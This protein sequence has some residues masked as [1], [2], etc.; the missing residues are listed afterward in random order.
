MYWTGLTED[1][2]SLLQGIILAVALVFLPVV[3]WLARR[4]EKKTAYIIAGASWTLVM[5]AIWPVPPQARAPI[6]VL[7]ALAGFGVAAAHLIPSAMD[8]DVLE[9]DE[10]MSGRRQEGAYTGVTV[11]VH[12]LAQAAVLALLPAALRWSGYVQPSAINPLPSQPASALTALRLL[13]SILPAL[14]LAVSIVVAWFYPI[15]RQRYTEMRQEL[16]RRAEREAG[17]VSALPR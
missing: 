13:V 15:T 3:L 12:K 6:Y 2:T 8:P 16:A 14:L 1:E 9:A 11:F 10:L 5:L 4:F 7:A 17:L